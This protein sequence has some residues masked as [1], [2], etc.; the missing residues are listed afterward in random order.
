MLYSIFRFVEA[1]RKKFGKKD[2][3]VQKKMFG[4]S[5]KKKLVQHNCLVTNQYFGDT[6]FFW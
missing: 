5:L 4:E 3:L 1:T 6:S 2:F